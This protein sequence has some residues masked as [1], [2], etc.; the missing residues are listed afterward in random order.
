MPVNP[1]L[2]YQ[3]L[4]KSVF[5][6]ALLP[7]DDNEL[8][9]ALNEGGEIV[10]TA[11]FNRSQRG[12]LCSNCTRNCWKGG[13]VWTREDYREQGI[14]KDLFYWGLEQLGGDKVYISEDSTT[15]RLVAARYE[16]AIPAVLPPRTRP[17]LEEVREWE[18]R[19][20]SIEEAV[21]NA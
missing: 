7:P 1:G 10:S 5:S 9:I 20:P 13:Y 4:P 17:P 14:F 6:V 15:Q 11:G 8:A 21:R 18:A 12:V 2:T 16:L 3:F 19:M